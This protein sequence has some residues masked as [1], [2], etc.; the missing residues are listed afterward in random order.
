MAEPQKV[1][2]W[3]ER[4]V[5]WMLL[6]PERTLGDAAREF[7]VSQP[8]LSVVKNS[9]AF[10]AY[11]E[12]RSAAFSDKL[13][14][15]AINCL[16]G[17]KEK[18]TIAAEA[19]L[20]EINRR[21]QTTGAVL[22]LRDLMDIAK[23]DLAKQ[24]YSATAK[25]SASSSVVVNIGSGISRAELAAAREKMRLISGA[26]VSPLPVLERRDSESSLSP[27]PGDYG[28]AEQK[29]LEGEIV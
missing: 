21:L 2:W 16:T 11:Y 15:Q 8:W 7:N 27:A 17:V 29:V 25:Q 9:D 20:D 19:A 24:G 22:P 13:E 3:Y 14:G 5:D 10:K 18:V 1:N 6:N 26:I 4:L 12:A 28:P 23:M